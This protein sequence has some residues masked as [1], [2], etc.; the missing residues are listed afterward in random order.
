MSFPPFQTVLQGS[1]P[2]EKRKAAILDEIGGRLSFPPRAGPRAHFAAPTSAPSCAPLPR[3]SHHCISLIV[4]PLPFPPAQPRQWTDTKSDSRRRRPAWT[5]WT[6]ASPWWPR[7]LPPPTWSSWRRA[8]APSASLRTA[9]APEGRS[10]QSRTC[11]R[12]VGWHN[13]LR[14]TALAAPRVS[15]LRRWR[16]RRISWRRCSRSTSTRSGAR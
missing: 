3:L 16:R 5:K 6:V 2:G 11:T 7:A 1:Q 8:A 9:E 14:V 4:Q 10:H 15:S 13:N 12:C